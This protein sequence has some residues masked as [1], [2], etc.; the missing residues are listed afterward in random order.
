M[1][2]I[3]YPISVW[4][5]HHRDCRHYRRQV[6][7]GDWR[8]VPG[9]SRDPPGERNA[10]RES[11]KGKE[12]KSGA[13]GDA[14]RQ[15]SSQHRRGGRSHRQ[16]RIIYLCPAAL[17]IWLRSSRVDS[18]ALRHSGLGSRFCTLLVHSQTRIAGNPEFGNPTMRFRVISPSSKSPHCGQL[19][20]AG[21]FFE[22][23]WY[24]FHGSCADIFF[25]MFDR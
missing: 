4:R 9:I 24:Q 8:P 5:N 2:R 21:Q 10:H 1:V 23:L 14:P 19:G 15:G 7:A 13:K 11:R 22:F 3:R 12:R 16:H 18:L 25:E 20:N 6:G 17:A